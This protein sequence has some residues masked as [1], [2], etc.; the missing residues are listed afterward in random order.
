MSVTAATV[1][2]SSVD[3]ERHVSATGAATAAVVDDNKRHKNRNA[4]RRCRE[5]RLQ[6]QREMRQQVIN[7]G[8]ENRR[9]EAKIRRFRSR[10]DQLQNLLSNHRLGL[11]GQCRLDDLAAATVTSLDTSTMTLDFDEL[12]LNDVDIT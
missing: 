2:C 5:K 11:F 4:A 9:L 3:V 7:V 6:R 1:G 10:V 8:T 12:P